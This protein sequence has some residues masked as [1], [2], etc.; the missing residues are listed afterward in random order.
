MKMNFIKTKQ[1]GANIFIAICVVSVVFLWGI[2]YYDS[3]FPPYN[4]IETTDE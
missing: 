4:E 3:K 1:I 2:M